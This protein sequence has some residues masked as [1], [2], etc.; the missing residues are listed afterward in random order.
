MSIPEKID[1]LERR[2]KK[3]GF[4]ETEPAKKFIAEAR[5]MY[6]KYIETNS[7]Y[8]DDASKTLNES[9]DKWLSMIEEE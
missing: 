4:D 5:N 8:A 1:E 6:A 3:V 7:E 2:F 9:L